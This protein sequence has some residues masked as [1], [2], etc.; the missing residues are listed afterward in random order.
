[1]LF[2]PSNITP[3]E[4][5]STGTVDLTQDLTVSWKVSGN[6][7]MTAYKITIYQNDSASTQM[8]TT[9]KTALVNPFWG[10][11]YAGDVQYFSATITAATLSS[12][13]ITNG[14]EYKLL[15][16]QWW[17][18]NDSVEQ[19]S[20][21]VFIGRA[22]PT[23]LLTAIPNPLE[24][25]QAS[26]T[27]TYSQAQG[28]PIKWVRWQIGYPT[29]ESG[30]YDSFVD[31]GNIYGTGELQVDY[32]G[33]LPDTTYAVKCTVETSN[34]IDITTGW[35]EFYVDYALPSTS[36]DANACQIQGD[37]GVWLSW[38]RNLS[39]DGYSIMRKT[40]GDNRLVK[41]ADVASTAG[42]IR[43]YSARSGN[44]YT[45]YVFPTGS[46]AYITQPMI[47]NAISVQYWF[48]A[49][50]E[51]KPTGTENE[52]SV[53]RTYLFRYSV[54]EGNTSNNNAPQISQNF[55]RF[56]TRQGVSANYATGTLSGYIGTISYESL[57]YSDTVTQAQALFDLSTTTNTLF[58]LDP[59][60]NFRKI[61]TSAAT[62]L[63]IDHKKK[64]MPQTM[65]ISWVEVGPTDGVH[66]IMYPG[67][68]FYPVDRVI[69]SSV[70]VDTAT[71]ALMWTVP[72][73]YTG[74]GSV[75][76]IA[77]GVLRQ[78]DSGSF[79]PATLALNDSTKILTA[80]VSE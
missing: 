60:G 6:S 8:Y 56:P 14:N 67:G 52:Y 33:F 80:S 16:T 39:A 25:K 28:D 50:I 5:N 45:Y 37:C 79:L 30:V 42:Q 48:W 38:E 21:S 75:L 9:G 31:T 55:T 17:S 54:S 15:I 1:M 7:A 44:T 27:A 4:I 10:V 11:N 35:N 46:L 36:G 22:N 26:F 76:S 13:S 68:D 40:N 18:A 47:S 65:T 2:Q 78:D 51:A 58:L 12:A 77:S 57:T 71:G 61:H 24:D 74:T 3:D 41:I 72:D 59:K 73:N 49:I 64:P 29:E 32:D 43:D 19:M 70:E 53:E 66:A 23:L 69:F 20:A 62:T 34:G 63:Q